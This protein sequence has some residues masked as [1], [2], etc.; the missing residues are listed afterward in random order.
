M[1]DSKVSEKD[2]GGRSSILESPLSYLADF[3]T[4]IDYVAPEWTYYEIWRGLSPY[5]KGVPQEPEFLGT[6]N[7]PSFKQACFIYELERTLDF[8]SSNVLRFENDFKI[9][10]NPNTISN[11]WVGNYYQTQEEAEESLKTKN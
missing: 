9:H 11:T 7:A 6:V 3:S 8:A 10:F 2:T 1:N 4:P 5:Y